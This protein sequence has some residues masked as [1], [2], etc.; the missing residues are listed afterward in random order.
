MRLFWFDPHMII[1][2]VIF[3]S[4]L[5]SRVGMLVFLD[6]VWWLLCGFKLSLVTDNKVFFA[7]QLHSDRLYVGKY[8]WDRSCDLIRLTIMTELLVVPLV[9]NLILTAIQTAEES[10]R[11]MRKFLS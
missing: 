10:H 7:N 1:S 6:I 2:L 11:V 5:T 3:G 4:I 9:G 8:L